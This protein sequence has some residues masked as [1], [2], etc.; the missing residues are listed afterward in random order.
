MTEARFSSLDGTQHHAGDK[1]FL[2]EGIYAQ[3]GQ[4]GNDDRAVFDDFLQ[5]ENAVL[6]RAVIPVGLIGDQDFP[7]EQLQRVFIPVSKEDG[8]VEPG[9]PSAH[10]MQTD[11]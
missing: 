2:H 6:R 7:Q 3:D 5:E 1:V 9:V 4:R 11:G 10:R 8:S